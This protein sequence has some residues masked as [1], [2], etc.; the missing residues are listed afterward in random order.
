MPKIIVLSTFIAGIVFDTYKAS[1]NSVS[2][3]VRAVQ[4]QE[5][6]AAPPIITICLYL[7]TA[8]PTSSQN[9]CLRKE[10]D[11]LVVSLLVA[12]RAL[13]AR[14]S[15]KSIQLVGI[16]YQIVILGFILVQ[17][18]GLLRVRAIACGLLFLSQAQE[19]LYIYRESY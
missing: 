16:T 14:F 9:F 15:L 10:L 6:R 3:T 5:D 2:N 8:N 11:G 7:A 4:T 18:L 17:I 12:K 19:D 13:R 1:V